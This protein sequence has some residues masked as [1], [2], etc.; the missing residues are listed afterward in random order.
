MYLPLRPHHLREHVPPLIIKRRSGVLLVT[1]L[2]LIDFFCFT[3]GH[4]ESRPCYLTL[5]TNGLDS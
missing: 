1:V 2:I 3:S 4:L 5:F